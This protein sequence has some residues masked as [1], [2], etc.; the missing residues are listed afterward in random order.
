MNQRLRFTL[1]F[2]GMPD[3]VSVLGN[4]PKF[5]GQ[6]KMTKFMWFHHKLIQF[7]DHTS[8]GSEME[9]QKKLL[10]EESAN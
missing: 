4:M 3:L 5:Q 8:L 10:Q 6:P 9:N 2:W 1:M 7:G